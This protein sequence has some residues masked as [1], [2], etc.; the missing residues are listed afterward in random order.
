MS[1]AKAST[2]R[3]RQPG[4]DPMKI[5][6]YWFCRGVQSAIFHYASC[7]DWKNYK[8]AR[9]RKTQAAKRAK[10]RA[11]EMAVVTEQPKAIAQMQ[12]FPSETNKGWT[13]EIKMGRKW[14]PR[15]TTDRRVSSNNTRTRANTADSDRYDYYR[16]KNPEIDATSP[17][18]ICRLPPPERAHEVAW[19]KSPPP[20]RAVMEGKE[21]PA[22]NAPPRW[23]LCMIEKTED[24]YFASLKTFE[25]HHANLRAMAHTP[26]EFVPRLGQKLSPD[27]RMLLRDHQLEWSAAQLDAQLPDPRM[28]KEAHSK[29]SR[30]PQDAD[31][32]SDCDSYTSW[33]EPEARY[34]TRENLTPL[35]WQWD[36]GPG[37][38]SPNMSITTITNPKNRPHHRDRMWATSNSYASAY[39]SEPDTM[40]FTATRNSRFFVHGSRRGGAKPRISSLVL[41]HKKGKPEIR[42]ASYTYEQFWNEQA[43]AQTS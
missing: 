26:D 25:D 23:P 27:G 10:E 18:V 43:K 41:V 34:P 2:Q 4:Y 14:D 42:G 8:A 28:P 21:T 12:P 39:D 16:A 6:D 11:A 15:Q 29:P 38:I 36:D 30:L 19:M 17:P 5:F 32:E 22:E 1:P 3:N 24:E 37:N 20:S 40:N 31:I 35:S 7:N 33:L 9:D 13:A